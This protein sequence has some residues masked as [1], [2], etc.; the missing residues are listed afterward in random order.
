MKEDMNMKTKILSCVLLFSCFI[1]VHAQV[2]QSNVSNFIKGNIADKTEAV[3]NSSGKE[4]EQL[5]LKTVDF[6]LQN[7]EE[8]GT[9]DRD[10]NT[11]AVTGI[12]SLP[13]SSVKNDSTI[14]TKLYKLFSVFDDNTI[15]ITILN[16][17][18]Q[19]QENYPSR[20]SVEIIN[21]TLSSALAEKHAGEVEKTAIIALGKIGNGSS[22]TV[23]YECFQ[24]ETFSPLKKEISSALGNIADK[25]LSE[26]LQIISN[27]NV[28]QLNEIF[29]LIKDHEKISSSF[30][31]EVAENV[32]LQTINNRAAN[33]T[34]V[35]SDLKFNAYNLIVE[36]KWARASSLVIQYFAQAKDE[37][38]AGQLSETQFVQIINGFSNIATPEA[39]KALSDY[40][41]EINKKTEKGEKSSDVLVLTVIKTLGNLGSIN[42]LDQLLMVTYLDYPE[43]II[44]EAR[45]TLTKLK[46]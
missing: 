13:V 21:E 15:K 41:G 33:E 38:S 23:L 44:A 14:F 32:L 10:F 46:W 40:L 17:L 30:K 37:Y 9:D 16:K 29:V 36:Y 11:L 43:K 5:S 31:A 12:L 42:A 35:L 20:E 18:V 4:T 45:S 22:F 2:K 1:A 7:Y 28:E 24:S 34:S 25:S 27:S 8:I 19:F 26:I 6:I 3:K 39:S